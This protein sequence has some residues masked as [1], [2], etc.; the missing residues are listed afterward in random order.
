M[1]DILKLNEKQTIELIKQL[2][3]LCSLV[4]LGLQSRSARVGLY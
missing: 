2:Q 3:E 1:D 4:G